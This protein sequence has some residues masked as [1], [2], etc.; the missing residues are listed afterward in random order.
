MYSSGYE[1]DEHGRKIRSSFTD[2][3]VGSKGEYYECIECGDRTEMEGDVIEIATWEKDPMETFRDM[4]GIPQEDN[5]KGETNGN[6]EDI[7]E[8]YV[9]KKGNGE[10]A[11]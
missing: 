10:E 5:V 9:E 6:D 1:I 4:L 3:Y 2:M 7:F 11:E 8:V